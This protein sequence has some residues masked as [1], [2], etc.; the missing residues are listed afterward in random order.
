LGF[1]NLVEFRHF[2]KPSEVG[3]KQGDTSSIGV[4]QKISR[5]VLEIVLEV[6]ML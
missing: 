2:E 5:K 3:E 4:K 6:D 1:E